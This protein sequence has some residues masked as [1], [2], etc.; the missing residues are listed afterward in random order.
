MRSFLTPIFAC[1][2]LIAPACAYGQ[3][4]GLRSETLEHGGV[5]RHYHVHL[6][7][8]FKN[9]KSH[10]LVLA[11]HGGG[12]RGDRFDASTHGTITAA[13]DKRGFVVIFPEAINKHWNI[14]KTEA[15]K[16]KDVDFLSKL[17][18]KAQSDYGI[19]D[20]RVYATGISAGGFMAV[21]L[22]QRLAHKIAAVAPV[23]AQLDLAS[24]GKTPQHPISV[25][26]INGT[27]DPVV[28]YHGGDVK[29][30]G[31]GASR[32]KIL[33]TDETIEQFRVHNRC[34]S[35][36]SVTA[37]ANTHLFDGSRA[38]V[39]KYSGGTNGTEVVLVKV[40]GG[41]HT[42]PGGKQYLGKSLIGPVCRDF[43]ASELIFDFFL[44]HRRPASSGSSSYTH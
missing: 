39:K 43:K 5:T 44:R 7:P 35:T 42:W 19:D 17:I 30:F 40:I 8:A 24:R 28:P 27:K 2:L 31:R 18:D 34:S 25:M 9:S 41:G 6:P 12:G 15:L 36:A 10:P 16:A 37:L 11:L 23:T 20:K 29:L 21:I 38:E 1:T 3:G 14:D 26:I 4:T 22:A 13:A 32:G 33:S